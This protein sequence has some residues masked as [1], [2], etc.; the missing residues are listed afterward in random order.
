MSQFVMVPV[1]LD[2]LCLDS[3]QPSISRFVDFDLLPFHDSRGFVDV[4]ADRPNLFSEIDSEAFNSEN[5]LL[6]SGVHLHWALPDGLRR[7]AAQQSST[8]DGV[9]L[10][11]VQ[12]PAVPNRWLVVRS[13]QNGESF[14]VTAAWVVESDFTTLD[15]RQ[16]GHGPLCVSFPVPVGPDNPVPYRYLGRLNPLS[17]DQAWRESA[18]PGSYLKDFGQKL[19]ALGY[20]EPSFAA[21]YPNV[22][23]VFGMHDTE[24]RDEGTAT[25]YEIL[26]WYSDPAQDPFLSLLSNFSATSDDDA[27]S[28]LNRFVKPGEAYVGPSADLSPL[29]P[30]VLLRTLAGR[31]GWTLPADA[32]TVTREPGGLQVKAANGEAFEGLLCYSRLDIPASHQSTPARELDGSVAVA[33]GNTAGEAL[34]A[35]LADRLSS[36]VQTLTAAQVEE[37]IES[38]ELAPS[39]AGHNVDLGPKFREARHA[40]GF[41]THVGEMLWTV[42]P[43][44]EGVSPLPGAPAGDGSQDDGVTLPAQ[45]AS[46][47]D[48]LNRAQ[49]AYDRQ[50]FRIAALRRQLFDGWQKYLK[51]A[52]PANDEFSAEIFGVNDR[53][54]MLADR[55]REM[56]GSELDAL[57]SAEQARGQLAFDRSGEGFVSRVAAPGSAAEAL[58]AALD[59]TG[60][61]LNLVNQQRSTNNL[62]PLVLQQGP[63]PRYFAPTDPVVLLVD[64]LLAPSRRHGQDGR[65][66]PE[67]LLACQTAALGLTRTTAGRDLVAPL[68]AHLDAVAAAG[69]SVG[70]RV[71]ESAPWNPFLL[72]WEALGGVSHSA[73]TT[74]QTPYPPGLIRERGEVADSLLNLTTPASTAADVAPPRPFHGRAILSPHPLNLLEDRLREY[75][76]ARG[77]NLPAEPADDD[78]AVLERYST[79]LN[80]ALNNREN[81]DAVN[82]GAAA[83]PALLTAWLAAREVLPLSFRSLAQSLDGFHR[84]MLMHRVSLQLPIADPLAES[85][86]AGFDGYRDF[87]RRMASALGNLDHLDTA[88]SGFAYQPIRTGRM[89]LERL[90]VVDTFGQVRNAPSRTI[91][92]EAYRLETENFLSLSPRLVQPARLSLRW[93][94]A[95]PLLDIEMNDHPVS[96]PVCGWVVPDLFDQSL[97]LYD[98]D[99]FALGTFRQD[100]AWVQP[101]GPFDGPAR[102]EDIAQPFLRRLALWLKA[103]GGVGDVLNRLETALL[104]IDPE[105][106]ANHRE[107]AL[108]VGRPLALVRASVNLELRDPPALDQSWT[109]FENRLAGNAPSLRAFTSVQFPIRIGDTGQMNDGVAECWPDTPKG[110]AAPLPPDQ[111]ILWQS[112]DDPPATVYMLIDPRAAVHAACGILPVKSIRVPS[113]QFA[114]ALANFQASLTVAPILTPPRRTVLPLPS[115]PG[116]SWTWL[117]RDGSQWSSLYSEAVLDR[118]AILDTFP[119]KGPALWDKLAEV[120]WLKLFGDGTRAFV[121]PPKDP[122]KLDLGL[123]IDPAAILGAVGKLARVIEPISLQAAF[124]ERPEIREG[125]LQFNPG[126]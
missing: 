98:A 58:K 62:K 30:Q 52:Y 88:E 115:D 7:G 16:T 78:P 81:Q 14:D 59:R 73:E 43:P 123:D 86:P 36:Q 12:F 44:A 107:R 68:R 18:E 65:L 111:R 40:K 119:S 69:A 17:Q 32:L 9:D 27:R 33:V 125:Y 85:A 112:L 91:C 34:S 82:N 124:G 37:Q 84:G 89:R 113:D 63:G 117:Q 35:W 87:A 31:L 64:P 120:G 108:L 101:P 79:E 55:I 76:A 46:L 80:D 39:L 118:Q 93:M 109:E 22:I 122:S 66:H 83:D 15:S 28:L 54:P 25:R 102:P 110:L 126:F 116:V 70:I 67:G 23:G 121:V 51:A 72:E 21:F 104:G 95:D 38:F 41:T 3:P 114:P 26:G 19:T 74:G 57:D 96:T 4:N 13:R 53:Q 97:D 103:Q 105:S 60:T 77:I 47:L 106:F 6:G 99:G 61:E 48:E 90:R 11:P 75:L 71:Q 29:Y 45:F 20:G 92:S 49:Q 100:G 1:H 42:R 10:D 50:G 5:M 8:G 94:G 56:L 24:P 2:A